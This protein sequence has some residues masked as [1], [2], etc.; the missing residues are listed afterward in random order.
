M[1]LWLVWLGVTVVG[2]TWAGWF[3]HFPFGFP[4]SGGTATPGSAVVGA[5]IG[6]VGAAV[7]AIAQWFVLRRALAISP[8]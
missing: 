7:V 2:L 1:M 3:G 4:T 6:T 8:W 5:V